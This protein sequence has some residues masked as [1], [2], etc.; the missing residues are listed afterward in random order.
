VAKRVKE[1]IFLHVDRSRFSGLVG[2]ESPALQQR[3]DG[4]HH[5]RIAA[6]KDIRL[7]R[8]QRH[9]RFF[10]HHPLLHQR[11]HASRAP[12]KMRV[13]IG[14]RDAGDVG[15]VRPQPGQAFEF[16]AIT[17]VPAKAR[18]VQDHEPALGLIHQHRSQHRKVGRQPR[19]GG[20]EHDRL[21]RRNT[22]QREHAAGLRSEEQRAAMLQRKQARRELAAGDER[23]IKLHIPALHARRRDAVRAANHL[24]RLGDRFLRRRFRHARFAAEQTQH[25][26]W[27]GLKSNIAPSGSTRR[28]SNCGLIS[29]RPMTAAL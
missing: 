20:D 14:P 5:V 25:A 11:L 23:E 4:F 3:L 28:T 29:S 1:P 7:R 22:V 16:A 6:E 10:F 13:L 17:Q 26:N 2:L 19:P 9:A 18:A 24:V 15:E 12:V 8:I 27:P 21:A